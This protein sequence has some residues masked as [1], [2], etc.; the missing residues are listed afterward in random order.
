MLQME[1]MA[2]FLVELCLLC[3]KMIK[4]SPSMHVVAAAIYTSQCT[5][6]KD[7]YLELI[8]CSELKHTFL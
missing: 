5:F 1:N 3:Y 6:R 2:F 8:T 4:Y 7:P